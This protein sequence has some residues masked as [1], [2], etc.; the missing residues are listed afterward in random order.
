[1]SHDPSLAPWRARPRDERWEEVDRYI[2]TTFGIDDHV[3]RDAT[4][5]GM[6]AGLP[7]IQVSAAS[8]R[9][10]HVLAL[11]IGAKRIL[12]IGTLFGY[13]GIHLA[14]A[15][16]ADGKLVTLELDAKHADV[17]RKNFAR[18]GLAGR[19]ELRVGPAT[20]SL[21]A[22]AREGAA[23]FDMV[24]IDA[25]KP[26]YPGYLAS[27]LKLARVGTLIVADNVVRGGAVADASDEDVNVRA[28]RRFNELLAK[29]PRL[30]AGVIQTVGTKGYDGFALAVFVD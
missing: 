10:L 28:V 26:G 22:L 14:R 19:V 20:D 27:S 8:G 15:L 23:P 4:A 9:F 21:A 5:A 30:R 3:L 12:E 17:A 6:A 24:F 7:E 18:A 29:E 2:D 25:D 13:S 11:A 16:P 1:M